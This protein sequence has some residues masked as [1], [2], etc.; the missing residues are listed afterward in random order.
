MSSR[1][2]GL[3]L[4]SLLLGGAT[5]CV[6]TREEGEAMRGDIHRL[7]T[8]VA[9]IQRERGDAAARI[10]RRLL[11][12]DK[13][14]AELE[15][16][17]SKARVTDA[18][19]G[20]QI[21]TIVAE[22]QIL[23]GELEEARFEVGQ[24]KKSVQ[25]ILDRPPVAVSMAQQTQEAADKREA[26]VPTIAGAAV[27]TDKQAHYDWA[28]KLLDDGQLDDAIQAFKLFT[29]RHGKDPQLGDNAWFWM[30]EAHYRSARKATGKKATEDA[31]KHAIL[32]YNRV[33]NE[34]PKSDKADGVL[35]KIGLSFEALGFKSD[36]TAF[37]EELLAK[38]KKSP[39]AGEAKKRLRA[40]KKRGKSRK[41]RR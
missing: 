7:K 37:Y 29:E 36:A 21:E 3:L 23:R 6:T 17:L 9:A 27:P 13:R 20:V 35:L 19:T 33:L 28:K 4:T 24:A 10:D 34:H 40:I 5:G 22:I 15:S 8:E 31:Y 12:V 30:G 32:S 25:D 41:R 11:A 16:A 39:L 14:L 18:D 1:V 38:H 2:S 26:T